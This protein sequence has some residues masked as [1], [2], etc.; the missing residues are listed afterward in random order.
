MLSVVMLNVVYAQCRDLFIVMLNVVMLI[1]IML[2]FIMLSVV[3]LSVVMMSVVMMSVM[4][5]S[6]ICGYCKEALYYFIRMYI[7]SQKLID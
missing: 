2:S 6:N 4:A 7:A 3:M 1:V 5:Q